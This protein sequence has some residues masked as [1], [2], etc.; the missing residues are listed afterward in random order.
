MH[1]LFS[2]KLRKLQWGRQWIYFKN[3]IYRNYNLINVFNTIVNKYQKYPYFL[4]IYP[5]FLP[6]KCYYFVQT[7][8]NEY[9]IINI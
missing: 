9:E 2:E 8:V 3:K 4:L 1:F 5:L 6:I 7:L